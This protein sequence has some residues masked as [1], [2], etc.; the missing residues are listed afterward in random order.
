[1]VVLFGALLALIQA[2]EVVQGRPHKTGQ[3][4]CTAGYRALPLRSLPKG[5]ADAGM[6]PCARLQMKSCG[7]ES[8]CNISHGWSCMSSKTKLAA[9]LCHLCSP[10]STCS[11]QNQAAYD[12]HCGRPECDARRQS[13]LCT[14]PLSISQEAINGNDVHGGLHHQSSADMLGRSNLRCS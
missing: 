4:R 3:W 8:T 12:Y 10:V 7:L 11:N 5:T 6:H 9:E 2:L 1:M 13:G 14:Y